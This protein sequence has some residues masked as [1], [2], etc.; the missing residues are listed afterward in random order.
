MLQYTPDYTT[1]LY[2]IEKKYILFMY[3]PD[4]PTYNVQQFELSINFHDII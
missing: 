2:T 3:A 4:T 1:K